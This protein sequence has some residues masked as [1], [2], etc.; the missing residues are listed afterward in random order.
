MKRVGSVIPTV[1]I[2]SIGLSLLLCVT[3]SAAAPAQEAPSCRVAQS[4]RF[5]F[6]S[7]PWINLHHFLFQWARNLPEPL[8]GDR[9]PPVEILEADQL[10]GLPD[11]ER[12]A[13]TAAL[14]LYR[15]ELASENMLFNDRLVR[16]RNALIAADCGRLDGTAVA[17]NIQDALASAMPIYRARWWN[18]HD[19][20][21][22]AWIAEQT[23]LLES[24]EQALAQRLEQVYDGA[25]P[26]QPV[27]LD[28][29]FY[30]NWAG[31]YTTNG[32]DVVTLEGR[33]YPGL[34]GLEMIFHEVSHASFFEQPLKRDLSAA[35][36][37]LGE[38]RP[39]LLSHTIQ[40]MTPPEILRALLSEE[41]KPDFDSAG[42]AVLTR[43]RMRNQYEA[44]KPH[45]QAYLSGEITRT[46][47]LAQIA[48]SLSP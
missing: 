4:E 22:R 25:W 32:P 12:A 38:R 45:W 35:F 36:A 43:G 30:G 7:D 46:A 14:D 39:S 47:A 19:Q 24:H 34:Q 33:S 41:E 16:L 48:E 42:E 5:V 23:A 31:G 11:E 8:E 44:V 40:F 2:R 27:R 28:V 9:R 3:W 10:A 20:A 37:K 29:G 21:N 17:P 18:R 1:T 6:Y 15:E 13:W 26:D